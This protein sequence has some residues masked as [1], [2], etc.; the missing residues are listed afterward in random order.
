MTSGIP[1]PCVLRAVRI[2]VP[3]CPPRIPPHMHPKVRRRHPSAFIPLP[4]PFAC[5]RPAPPPKGKPSAY[6]PVTRGDPFGTRRCVAYSSRVTLLSSQAAVRA[7]RCAVAGLHSHLLTSRSPL[8]PPF[9]R[10]P[11]GCAFVRIAFGPACRSL[12]SSCAPPLRPGVRPSWRH[13]ELSSSWS[14]KPPG[15]R[16]P[17]LGETDTTG[18]R[19]GVWRGGVSWG[20]TV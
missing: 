8:R 1:H 6:A 10:S 13:R 7:P 5:P 15:K 14:A 11:C 12:V 20:V 2:R 4:R 19:T 16:I 17:D 18:S 3:V 9:V